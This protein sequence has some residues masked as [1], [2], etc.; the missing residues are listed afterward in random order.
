MAMFSRRD[1]IEILL[2][3][4]TGGIFGACIIIASKATNDPSDVLGFF[5]GA[6]GAGLAVVGA[7]WVEKQKGGARKKML[8]DSLVSVGAAAAEFHSIPDEAMSS[9]LLTLRQVIQTFD[10]VR[11][12][13]GIDDAM[14]QLSMSA[15]IHWFPIITKDID[16]LQ[17]RLKENKITA[18]DAKK[19]FLHKADLIYSSVESTLLSHPYWPKSAL[20]ML[21]AY[22]TSRKEP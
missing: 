11:T 7:L 12:H 5:G 9:M 18:S 8:A 22:K 17:L 3:G 16:Q 6:V 1:L 15:L 21:Q 4:A 20:R 19:E 10:I 2:V 14:A 13:A